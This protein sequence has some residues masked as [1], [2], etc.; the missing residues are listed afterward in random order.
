[1]NYY[2][3]IPFFIIILFFFPIKLEAR[4]SFNVLNFSGAVGVFLFKIKLLHQMFW[5]KGKKIITQNDDEIETVEM[6]FHS[7]E[8]IFLQTFM[9][10]IKDKTRLKQLAVFYNIGTGDAFSSAMVAGLVNFVVTSLFTNIKNQKPTASLSL[11]NT[12]SYNR[13]IFQ[14]ALTCILSISLFDVLYSFCHSIVLSKHQAEQKKTQTE[15][16]DKTQT[17]D[18]TQN[19]G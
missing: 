13:E 5:I 17:E 16:E 6:D 2:L 12:I 11:N 18:K 10:E 19:A 7:E 14:F 1:M 15:N 9:K 8:I 3:F 4:A